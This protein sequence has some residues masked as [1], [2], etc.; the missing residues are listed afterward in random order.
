MVLSLLPRGVLLP[1]L[2][3]E[4]WTA[5]SGWSRIEWSDGHVHVGEIVRFD[6]G[7]EVPARCG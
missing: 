3:V 2:S 6:G 5:G 7:R 4:T 1:P